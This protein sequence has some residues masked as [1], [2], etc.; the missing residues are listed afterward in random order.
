MFANAWDDMQREEG[1]VEKVRDDGATYWEVTSSNGWSCGVKKKHGI[2]PKVG[3]H[4]VTWGS[5][6]RPIRGIAVARRVLFYRTPAEQ[7][8]ENQ[9]QLDESRAKRVADYEGKRNEF[10]A[11]VAALPA[12]LRDRIEKFRAFKGDEWRWEFE[13]YELMCCEE[14]QKLLGRFGTAEK[15]Q[16][17]AKLG[18]EEQKAAFPEMDDGHSGNSWGFSLRLAYQ[19]ADKPGYV[20]QIHGALCPLVGCEDYGCYS[21]RE[22]AELSA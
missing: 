9:K 10:D 4:F 8:V 3:D 12:A 19:L 18:Y 1:T 11:R 7:E 22:K 15:I 20:W 13:S 14:A 6:G 17:F 2:E 5:I 16:A 21:T